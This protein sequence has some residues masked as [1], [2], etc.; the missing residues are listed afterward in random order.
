MAIDH[1]KKTKGASSIS[2]SPTAR[3]MV[4]KIEDAKRKKAL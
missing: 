3:A 4:L 1:I 2:K